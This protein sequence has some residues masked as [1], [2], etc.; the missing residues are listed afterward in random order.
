MPGVYAIENLIN[1]KVYVGSTARSLRTRWNEHRCKL[2]H[3]THGN[4][5]LQAAWRKYGTSEF[6]FIVLEETAPDPDILVEREQHWLD[7]YR[8]R[9][10]VYNTGEVAA[11]PSLGY[12]RGPFSAEHR[13]KISEALRGRTFSDEH[14]RR[15]SEVFRSTECKKAGS[16]P[17]FLNLQTGEVIPPG[18]NLR[19]L[20]R[21]RGFDSGNM[22]RLKNG[23]LEHYRAW[24]VHAQEE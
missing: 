1:G 17:A 20:C 11:S 2:S 19:A 14:R 18:H 7:R 23:Q 12:A 8:A 16:Y 13:Q 10:P 24:I 22:C 9:R 4:Q 6:V 21:E 3:G 15:L 5:H